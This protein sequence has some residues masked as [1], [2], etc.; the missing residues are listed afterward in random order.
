MR[1]SINVDHI[2]TI[3]EARGGSEP[4]PIAAAAIAE[5]SGCEGITIHLRSDRRHINERD[6]ELLRKTIKTRL[7]LEMAATDEM[8]AIA[9]RVKPDQVTLVPE[10]PEELTTEAVEHVF[11]EGEA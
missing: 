2:A 9:R 7:N 3:R 5:L 4:E 8:V 1:L 10:S 6:L 11:C